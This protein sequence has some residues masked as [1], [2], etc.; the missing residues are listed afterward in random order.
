M[1]NAMARPAESMGAARA[2]KG[3]PE[4]A[5]APFNSERGSESPKAH[6]VGSVGATFY[7]S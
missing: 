1:T 5:T 3:R 2:A 7:G 4:Q 6:E